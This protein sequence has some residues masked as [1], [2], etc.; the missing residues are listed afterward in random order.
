M[1]RTCG[2]S[3]VLE[4]SLESGKSYGHNSLL[5]WLGWFPVGQIL[6]GTGVL[7]YWVYFFLLEDSN[8]ANS[9]I[10]LAYERAF[11]YA[12]VI[13]ITPLLFLSVFWMSKQNPKGIV[14][15]IASGGCLVF[16]GLVDVTYNIQQGI[17]AKSIFDAVL[18]GFINLFCILFGLIS[19]V[20]GWYL[21]KNNAVNRH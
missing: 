8:P 18:N 15:T 3:R 1:R 4:G 9:G 14:T 10:W 5:R 19:V 17:Y 12:D 6:F 2:V 20:W 16:L 13:W 7:F 21:I 11:P